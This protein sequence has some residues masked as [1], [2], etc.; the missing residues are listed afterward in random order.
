MSRTLGL[1]IMNPASQPQCSSRAEWCLQ[2]GKAAKTL[3]P[4]YRLGCDFGTPVVVLW[5][6]GGGE[7]IYVCDSH[8][9]Q[10]GR[11]RD[12]L[13]D[14]RIIAA[15]SKQADS[16]AQREDQ[17]RPQAAVAG[18]SAQAI[19]LE[20]SSEP[21]NVSKSENETKPE[22][23][24]TQQAARPVPDAKPDPPTIEVRNKPSVRDLAYGNPAKAMVDE[25]IWNM[26]AGNYTAFKA[27]LAQ[28]KSPSE[29]ADAAGG[30]LAFLHRKI[31]EYTLK[32]EAIF[33][34]SQA[35]VNVA[36]TIDKPLEKAISDVINNNAMSD[37]EKDAAIEQLGMLQE[38]LKRGLQQE[39]TPL[40]AHKT[41]LA[42][43]DR[44]D[45][46]G[47]SS[48]SEI[49]KTACRALFT[50]FKTALCAAA[51]EAQ[52]LHDRLTNLYAAKSEMESR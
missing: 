21:G 42:I 52:N 50:S 24:P 31:N 47:N 43:A 41:L 37:S 14:A 16:P 15:P 23:A 46:G 51:P 26:A 9:K 30:Q 49:L 17:T 5:K 12:H 33:S 40:Q 8:A 6:E 2:T 10:L 45:W 20:K 3:S 36:E 29:A 35:T 7:P 27:A 38:S 34:A 4:H 44:S 13:Q 48:A 11:S 18:K 19:K 28:G 32:L 39:L 22:K 25:A 1:A